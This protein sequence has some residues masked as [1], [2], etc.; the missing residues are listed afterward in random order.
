M[1]KLIQGIEMEIDS[2]HKQRGS[3]LC[4]SAISHIFSVCEYLEL[5][6]RVKYAAVEIYDR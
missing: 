3:A 1:E 2:M 5:S 6:D 4:S